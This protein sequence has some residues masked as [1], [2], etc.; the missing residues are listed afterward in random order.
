MPRRATGA[1]LGIVGI[2]S[3][4]AAGAQDVI[5]GLLID[6]SAADGVY[7]FLPVAL[8]W[9]SACLV[10]FVLPVIGWKTLRK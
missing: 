10:S 7:N 1:A 4:V 8:F 5:S 3:Y 2:S 6:G 9:L